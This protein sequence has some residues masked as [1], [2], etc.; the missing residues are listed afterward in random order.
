[1]V[2]YQLMSKSYLLGRFKGEAKKI[3]GGMEVNGQKIMVTSERDANNLKWGKFGAEYIAECTGAYLKKE[4]AE[5]HIKAGAKKILMSA[6]AKDD[7][8]LFVLGVNHNEYTPD[9]VY[10]SNASCTTNCLAPIAKVINDNWGIT[11][12]LMTTVHSATMN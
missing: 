6:P 5:G 2:K 12:G 3:E 7:T 10:A 8:P 4:K 1:M 9:V 11:E